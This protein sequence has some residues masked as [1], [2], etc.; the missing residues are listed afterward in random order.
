MTLDRE[1]LSLLVIQVSMGVGGSLLAA[2]F[3]IQAYRLGG[4]LVPF[5]VVTVPMVGVAATV[6]G[7][8]RPWAYLLATVGWFA[9]M[10]LVGSPLQTARG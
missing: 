9:L 5:A 4:Y 2:I 3:A 6:F 10:L 7:R 1:S 8:I